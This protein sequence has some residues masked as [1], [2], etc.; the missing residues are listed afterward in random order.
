MN[1]NF[2]IQLRHK[3]ITPKDKSI[4]GFSIPT[5][6]L[7]ATFSYPLLLSLRN[8]YYLITS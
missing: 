8:F 2:A 1:A 7:S 6:V 5:T 4:D 3:N